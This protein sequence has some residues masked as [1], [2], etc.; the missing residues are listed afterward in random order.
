[1]RV[2]HSD[3]NHSGWGAVLDGSVPA[4]GM[5]T[6]KE[7]VLHINQKEFLVVILGVLA[8]AQDLRP[9]KHISQS[10]DSSVTRA[11]VLN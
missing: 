2:L 4:R 7:R 8:F 1:M 9:G 10:V 5:L 6:E 3:V 11:S